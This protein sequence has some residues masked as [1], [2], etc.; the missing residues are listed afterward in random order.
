LKAPEL[1]W[2]GVASIEVALKIAGLAIAISLMR[3]RL[4]MS[5]NEFM[6]SILTNRQFQIGHS[7][8]STLNSNAESKLNVLGFFYVTLG[9]G[10][11]TQKHAIPLRFSLLCLCRRCCTDCRRRLDRRATSRLIVR[12]YALCS[13]WSGQH[14]HSSF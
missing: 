4:L 5:L 9:G 3:F 1:L 11:S 12:R 8:P 10:Q 14:M 13:R 6:D 7:T 2:T